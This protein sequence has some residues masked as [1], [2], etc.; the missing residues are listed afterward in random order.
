MKLKGYRTLLFNLV[1]IAT[2]LV[3]DYAALLPPEYL[4]WFGFGIAAAN[5]ILRTQTTTKVGRRE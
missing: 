3:T 1:A 4:P 2:L 5:I